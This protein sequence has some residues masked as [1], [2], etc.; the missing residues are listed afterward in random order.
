MIIIIIT[1][2]SLGAGDLHALVV[3]A[4]LVYQILVLLAQ[5]CKLV[6]DALPCHTKE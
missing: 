5:L 4:E 3:A 1:T 6:V 2:N